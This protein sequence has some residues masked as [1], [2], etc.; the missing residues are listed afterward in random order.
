MHALEA[1]GGGQGTENKTSTSVLTGLKA[2]PFKPEEQLHDSEER[3][4]AVQTS[5]EEGTGEGLAILESTTKVKLEVH[6]LMFPSGE[7]TT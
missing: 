5:M 1:G 7:M 4:T 2:S 3:H 6:L